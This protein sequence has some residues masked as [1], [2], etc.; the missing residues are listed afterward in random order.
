MTLTQ[1]ISKRS[2]WSRRVLTLIGQAVFICAILAAYS[3]LVYIVND[4]PIR[5]SKFSMHLVHDLGATSKASR[6]AGDCIQMGDTYTIIT[7]GGSATSTTAIYVFYSNRMLFYC[8]KCTLL[9]TTIHE[10]GRF[11][12]I[13]VSY[14]THC[15]PYKLSLDALIASVIGC[16]VIDHASFEVR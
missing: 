5:D 9:S 8:E 7:A 10:V 15:Q 11:D 14:P 16:G 13:G 2:I 6:C 1:P 4:H 3:K 12:I